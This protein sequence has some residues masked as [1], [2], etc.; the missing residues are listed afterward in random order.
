MTWQTTTAGDLIDALYWNH[1]Q[2]DLDNITLV[3]GRISAITPSSLAQATIDRI[4]A[5]IAQFKAADLAVIT[6]AI[7]SSTDGRILS[8][9]DVL[10]WATNDRLVENQ[11]KRLMASREELRERIKIALDV[12]YGMNAPVGTSNQGNRRT[13]S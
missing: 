2:S 9:A 5:L 10:E 4:E 11:A 7:G 13:R 8:K 12:E 3:M 6:G 1:N